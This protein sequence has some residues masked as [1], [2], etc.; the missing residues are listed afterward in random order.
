MPMADYHARIAQLEAQRPLVFSSAS[1]TLVALGY[2]GDP[3]ARVAS[4]NFWRVR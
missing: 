2:T 4:Q 3:L 1:P